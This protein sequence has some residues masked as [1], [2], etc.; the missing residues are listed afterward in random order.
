MWLKNTK[1]HPVVNQICRHD[2]PM[3]CWP[4]IMLENRPVICYKQRPNLGYQCRLK[5]AYMKRL[6]LLTVLLL[7][8]PGCSQNHFNIPAENV[9]RQGP[10]AR[11]RPHHRRC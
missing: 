2:M 3:D 1:E 4:Q 10:G 11:R 5:E 8:F 9:R 6:L 7:I